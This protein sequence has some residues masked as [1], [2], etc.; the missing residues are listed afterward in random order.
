MIPGI[1]GLVSTLAPTLGPT[2]G[3]WITD[4]ASWRW[5]FFMNVIPGGIVTILILMWARVDEAA[6]SMLRRI[7]WAHMLSMAVFLGGLEYVLEEGPRHDWLTEPAVAIAA[8]LSFV[9]ALLFLE[10]SFFSKGPI[11]KLTAFRRPTF[12]FACVFNFVIGV[13][14]YSATYLVPVFLGRVRGYSS[15]EIGTT[16]FVSGIAMSLGAPIAA[17]L[18][19]RVDQRIVIT[20][21]LIL[22]AAGLWLFSY[23]TP[24]W[25]SASCPASVLP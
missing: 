8:W 17:T 6:P 20:F 24:D 3:G 23:M 18:S 9:S 14:L 21:G 22:F 2:V 10:R 4:V 16:V 7:D 25:G 15:F 5:L 13:G 19:Q 11:V 12:V 1:L